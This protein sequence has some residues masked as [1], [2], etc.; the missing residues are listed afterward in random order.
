MLKI[1]ADAQE[2]DNAFDEGVRAAADGAALAARLFSARGRIVGDR[3]DPASAKSYLSGLLIGADVASAPTLINLDPSQSVALVGDHDL[4]R[5]YARAMTLRG[6][7]F[8]RHSGDE[9]VLKG[10]AAIQRLAG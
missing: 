8:T 2:D 4:C 3:A 9:A 5:L 7:A 6:L 1:A 10:L